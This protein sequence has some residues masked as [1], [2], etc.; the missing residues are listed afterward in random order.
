MISITDALSTSE[1]KN[2]YVIYPYYKK[3]NKKLLSKLINGYSSDR[4]EFLTIKQLK[5]I[6]KNYK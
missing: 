1:F 6:I 2:Y 3:K 4:N 5:N